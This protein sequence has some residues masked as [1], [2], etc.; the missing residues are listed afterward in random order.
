MVTF[1]LDGVP[2]F[3][4]HVD[5]FL[6]RLVDGEENLVVLG[7]LCLR[8]L[9]LLFSSVSA[10]FPP[11]EL[12]PSRPQASD[13]NVHPFLLPLN[14]GSLLVLK[15]RSHVHCDP[16]N[17]GDGYPNCSLGR[18]G[19]GAALGLGVKLKYMSENKLRFLRT[20]A[21]ETEEII[22]NRESCKAFFAGSFS[23]S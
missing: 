2:L 15:P 21:A 11:L 3:V 18:F 4:L 10:S 12:C 14:A 22:L 23:S 1:G 19:G 8:N 7:G 9:R 13:W 17:Q 5:R 16:V 20:P 6:L